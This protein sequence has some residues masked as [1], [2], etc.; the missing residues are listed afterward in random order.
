MYCKYFVSFIDN[1]NCDVF[2]HPTYTEIC[3]YDG[4]K[5]YRY[6]GQCANCPNLDNWTGGINLWIDDIRA[7]PEG[8]IWFKSVNETIEF[9]DDLCEYQ[10]H[11]LEELYEFIFPEPEIVSTPSSSN[12]ERLVPQVPLYE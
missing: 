11:S 9:I 10:G 3:W 1:E 2:D 4:T 6:R 12:Q 7:A 5:H 8:F